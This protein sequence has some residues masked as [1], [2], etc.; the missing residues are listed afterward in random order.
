MLDD[1][2]KK[3]Y[4]NPDVKKWLG[5]IKHA[6]YEAD[7]LLDEIATDAPMKKLRAE[8]QP[9][10]SNIFNFIPAFNNPFE[11][12]IKELITSLDSLAD[13]MDK[14]QLKK[15]TCARNEFGLNSKPS[16]RLPTTYLVDASSIYGRDED[17]D[18]KIKIL[19][20]ENGTQNQVP[21]ISIVGLGGMGKTTFAMLVFNDRLIEE[22]FELKA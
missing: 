7:Q 20:S 17:K 9:S 11:S 10:T 22:H 15:Q 3:Q 1:A 18:K 14:L 4:E 6:M 2:E 19:L 21:V 5:D 8:F 13:K 12:R 16:E